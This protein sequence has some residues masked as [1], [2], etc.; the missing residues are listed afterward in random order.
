MSNNGCYNVWEPTYKEAPRRASL[1]FAVIRLL[2]SFFVLA[3]LG[4]PADNK[5]SPELEN[6]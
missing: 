1:A 6:R 4:L 2:A 5:K 3:T